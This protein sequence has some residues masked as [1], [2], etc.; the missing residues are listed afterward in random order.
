MNIEELLT[1]IKKCQTRVYQTGKQQK[2]I[3]KKAGDL[4]VR[5][6]TMSST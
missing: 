3:R 2:K 4:S 6:Q 5:Q 1:G